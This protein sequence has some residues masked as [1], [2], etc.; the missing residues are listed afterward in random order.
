MQEAQL[1]WNSDVINQNSSL[2]TAPEDVLNTI[3]SVSQILA[4]V[5]VSLF[6]VLRLYT[7][8]FVA[9]PWCAEDWMAL[10]A[11]VLSLGYFAAGLLTGYFGGGFHIYELSKEQLK[12]FKKGVYIITLT[13]SSASYFTKLALLFIIIRVFGVHKK[14]V[15]G[16]YTVVIFL[17]GY[18]IPILFLKGFICRPLAGFWDQ[19]II[20]TCYNQQAIFIADTSISAVTDMAVLILPVPVAVTLRMSWNK[21]L[22]VI[23]MLS[24]GGIA[25]AV[26]LIRLVLVIKMQ[27]SQDESVD[28]IRGNLL[29]T[30]EV[31]TGLICAC[32][33]AINLLLIRVVDRSHKS[34]HKFRDGS[35]EFNPRFLRGSEL[36]TQRG[37]IT[38]LEST[39]ESPLQ[40]IS[41]DT[42]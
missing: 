32:L 40:N 41:V 8:T 22:R 21:R 6:A 36:R 30:A 19:T 5:F 27:N 39:A 7:K 3:N 35:R 28:F 2:F 18:S 14:T 11:W 23:A 9:P 10:I 38:D 33:P 4:L 24:S 25:T 42:P 1:G 29:G 17:T 34:S 15:I 20:T 26:S 16:T 31:S 13:Y 12:G 37:Q